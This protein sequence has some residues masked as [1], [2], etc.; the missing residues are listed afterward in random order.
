MRSP[1]QAARQIDHAIVTAVTRRKPVY[2][3]IACNIADAPIPPSI[4][5]QLTPLH[6]RAPSN[7]ESLVAATEAVLA[8]WQNAVRPV[9]VVGSKVRDP[10]RTEW[11]LIRSRK[12]D[13]TVCLKTKPL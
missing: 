6:F 11:I 4:P 2:I 9:I 5:F 13:G 7:A 8:L 3:E 10:G 12:E 1:A